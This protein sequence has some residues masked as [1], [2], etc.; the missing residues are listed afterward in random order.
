MMNALIAAA[1][2]SI[3]LG[4]CAPAAKASYVYARRRDRRARRP[5]A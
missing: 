5:E 3:I 2:C 1:L 4:C